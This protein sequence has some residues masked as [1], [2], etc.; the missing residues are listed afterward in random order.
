MHDF[1][2]ITSFLAAAIL[3]GSMF[4]GVVAEQPKDES[5]DNVAIVTDD[6]N[7]HELSVPPLDHVV[8]PDNRPVWIS[9]PVKQQGKEMTFV[10]VS[11]PCETP[12][13]SKREVKLMLR[14]T[15]ST[16]IQ[17]VTGSFGNDDFYQI[18]DQ[19]IDKDL[20]QRRY[21]GEITVGGN[22]QYEDALDK[23]CS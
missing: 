3:L 21:A 2:W 7:P 14:A 1:Q 23:Y 11:G 4:G 6:Q 13:E 9:G 18:S 16:F 19:Q 22:T 5:G 12:E 10:V 15:L 20:T 8:Y 17:N